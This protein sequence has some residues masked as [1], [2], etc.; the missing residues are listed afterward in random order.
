[1]RAMVSFLKCATRSNKEKSSRGVQC[2]RLA[3][4]LGNFPQYNF[5]LHKCYEIGNVLPLTQQATAIWLQEDYAWFMVLYA[6]PKISF[7]ERCAFN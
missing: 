6:N 3:C 1:M 5:K 7:A 4:K 2:F